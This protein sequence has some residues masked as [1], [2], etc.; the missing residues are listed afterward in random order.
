MIFSRS[1]WEHKGAVELPYCLI[2]LLPYFAKRIRLFLIEDWE[3]RRIAVLLECGDKQRRKTRAAP[4]FLVAQ[5]RCRA[6]YRL[7]PH[8]KK[9]LPSAPSRLCEKKVTN[10]FAPA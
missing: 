9:S 4:L 8:S 3:E 7:P 5:K 2:A 10:Q 6:E 1:C